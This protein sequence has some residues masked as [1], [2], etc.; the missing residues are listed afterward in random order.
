[1]MGVFTSYPPDSVGV[2][3]RMLCLA[4]RPGFLLV[5]SGLIRGSLH[6]A[7]GSGIIM[8]KMLTNPRSLTTATRNWLIRHE[9]SSP[10]QLKL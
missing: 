10:A 5:A 3:I 2:R 6:S 1:M 8:I 4:E 7:T 9:A